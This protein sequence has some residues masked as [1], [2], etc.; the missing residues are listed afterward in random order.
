MKKIFLTLTLLM[1]MTA[2]WADDEV[3]FEF[4][5]GIEG[6]IKTKMEKQLSR[7][8]TAINRA[9]SA[10]SKE[11]NFSGIT[12]EQGELGSQTVS[13]LWTDVHFHTQDDD[14][15]QPCLLHRRGGKVTGYQVRNIYMDMIPL[16]DSYRED[17]SQEFVIDFDA[18]GNI[19]DVNIA[20][21]K[22]QYEKLLREGEKLADFDRREQI[23][24]F[25]EDFAN[26]YCKKD[27]DF[28]KDIFSDDALIITGKVRKRTASSVTLTKKGETP[29]PSKNNVDYK[30]QTKEEY[31]ANLAEVFK[32]ASGS[33]YINVKF[34]DYEIMKHGAKPN[35]YC[36]TL[37]QQWNSKNRA[38]KEYSDEGVVFLIWNFTDEDNP[39]IEVRVWQDMQAAKDDPMDMNRFKLR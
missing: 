24:K 34:D 4:S 21:G 37:R 18:R 1:S 36:V 7:L 32:A 35:Y 12:F 30:V 19:S 2:L 27:I 38:G 26:A 23:V 33:G 22:L 16:S 9:A 13:M 39:K 14:F 10:N 15:Y 3:T 5:Q 28:M 17:K 6:A 8:L 31:L 29:K 25:C 11:I 20:K